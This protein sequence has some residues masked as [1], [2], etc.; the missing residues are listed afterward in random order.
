MKVKLPN[1]QIFLKK[2]NNY[3]YSSKKYTFL[4]FHLIL[5]LSLTSCD[6]GNTNLDSTRPD[7]A[8]LKEILPTALAQTAHNLT[9]I[10]SRIT[11]IISFK[12]ICE[13]TGR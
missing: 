10:G 2:E 3:R 11:G 7:D 8:E 1:H 4:I 9:S 12:G 13:R 6:F 5:I